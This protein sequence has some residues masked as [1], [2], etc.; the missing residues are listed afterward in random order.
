MIPGSRLGCGQP[1]LV[2]FL[3]S[4][5]AFLLNC[6]ISLRRISSNSIRTGT[7]IKCSLA[8]LSVPRACSGSS[9][10]VDFRYKL[11]IICKFFFLYYYLHNNRFPGVNHWHLRR[12]Q[13]IVQRI[14]EKHGIKYTISHTIYEAIAKH[15]SL[16]DEL[17][18]ES[19]VKAK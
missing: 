9:S 19:S 7:S 17:S 11:N 6:L 14:C 10:R 16:L 8:I 4:V 5:S 3:V 15:M 2:P 12:I 1:S 18:Q 13:P